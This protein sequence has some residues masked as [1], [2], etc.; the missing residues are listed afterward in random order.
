MLNS[1]DALEI[2]R[3]SEPTLD[4]LTAQT[5]LSMESAVQESS[6]ANMR[7]IAIE[8]AMTRGTGNQLYS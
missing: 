5:L 7:V 6:R 3:L 2:E 4:T 8:I 1:L